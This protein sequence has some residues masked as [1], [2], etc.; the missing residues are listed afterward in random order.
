MI[1]ASFAISSVVVLTLLAGLS[2]LA[3][4]P[5]CPP[6]L[7]SLMPKGAVHVAGQYK[8]GDVIEMGT[9]AADLPFVDVCDQNNKYPARIVLEVRHYLD[10]EMFAAAA[11]ATERYVV[12]RA[13]TELQGQYGAGVHTERV[14]GGTLV[15]F[16]KVVGCEEG[17]SQPHVDMTGFGRTGD[18]TIT[19][20]IGG[21]ASAAAAKAWATEVIANL[22]KANFGRTGK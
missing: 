7:A 4:A 14:A 15:Y 13:Q 16:D 18:A 1:K 8:S 3:Q 22:E 17:K 6:V 11:D 10:S 5:Q 12:Q 20:T 9:A 19:I 2:A 21:Y